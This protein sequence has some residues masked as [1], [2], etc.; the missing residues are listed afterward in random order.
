MRWINWQETIVFFACVYNHWY[1]PLTHCGLLAQYGV[2]ELGQRR[3]RSICSY[4]C[5]ERVGPVQ[6]KKTEI[7]AFRFISP[8]W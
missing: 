1:L 2:I 5:G 6:P 3:N 4:L 7:S 8:E